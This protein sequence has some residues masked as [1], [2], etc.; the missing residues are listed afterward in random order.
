VVTLV[1]AAADDPAVRPYPGP[2][3]PPEVA[4]VIDYVPVAGVTVTQ[5]VD[6]YKVYELSP[7]MEGAAG[8]VVF[9]AGIK[10]NY[11]GRFSTALQSMILPRCAIGARP[12]SIP[13][14]GKLA[15]L[16][17]LNGIVKLLGG[18]DFAIVK[19]V[20]EI[21]GCDR[22]ALVFRLQA[23]TTGQNVLDAY[24]GPCDVRPE[25][26]TCYRP[27]IE[28]VGPATPDCDGNIE[29]DFQHFLVGNVTAAQ[30]AIVLDFDVGMAEVC[31]DNALPDAN[32]RLQTEFTDQCAT[33]ILSSISESSDDSFTSLSLSMESEIGS[34]SIESILCRDLP[35]LETFDYRHHSF[36]TVTGIFQFSKVDSPWESS[37]Q[38]FSGWS[39]W[40]SM[41]STLQSY[42]SVDGSLY[43]YDSSLV[44][45]EWSSL[46]LRSSSSGRSDSS[47]EIY[48]SSSLS[49]S[50]SLDSSSE[51]H[52]SSSDCSYSSLRSSSSLSSYSEV[53]RTDSVSSSSSS[54]SMASWPPVQPSPPVSGRG[55]CAERDEANLLTL[56]LP[57]WDGEGDTVGDQTSRAWHLTQTGLSWV[58]AD[59]G[60]YAV[61]FNG[62][63]DLLE[64]S[65]ETALLND[66]SILALF[67]TTTHANQTLVCLHDDAASGAPLQHVSLELTSEG[68]LAVEWSPT[69]NVT[70]R[71]ETEGDDFADGMWHLVIAER[72]GTS[73]VIR[74]DGYNVG[75]GTSETGGAWREI[76]IGSAAWTIGGKGQGADPAIEHFTGQIGMVS[77]YDRVTTYA[78]RSEWFENPWFLFY[79][80]HPDQ[81][82][83]CY[84][85]PFVDVRPAQVLVPVYRNIMLRR[86]KL[87][88]QDAKWSLAAVDLSRRKRRHP[89][90]LRLRADTEYALPCRPNDPGPDPQRSSRKWRAHHQSSRGWQQ[91]P[92]LLRRTRYG[93]TIL[94]HSPL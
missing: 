55:L 20:R 19:D 39:S 52:F 16:S 11:R 4:S 75:G 25:A 49:S 5:P 66:F 92:A 23:S 51:I 10:E 15:N 1:F 89:G 14:L 88:R 35:I 86:S 40:S 13:S 67:K 43:S 3:G 24:R 59:Y 65:A 50:S 38:I 63:T 94:V 53:L 42:D 57:F 79:D 6:P 78:E 84:P 22:E 76:S 18:T 90:R 62:T 80:C 45:C 70:Y 87:V 71:V 2:F 33:D 31:R 74:V 29:I 91:L 21:D 69:G 7:I 83:I 77:V 72:Q 41:S 34:E 30:G 54:S 48:S 8:W 46:S 32:G 73:V 17:P 61:E 28:R 85:V 44:S 12:I 27:G 56:A 68:Y 60:G 36:T 9:G 47:S 37:S 93:H 82:A 64:S 26:G 81:I 58:T